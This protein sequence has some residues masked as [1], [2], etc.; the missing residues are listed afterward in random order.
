M[1]KPQILVWPEFRVHKTLALHWASETYSG[2]HNFI[3]KY[4]LYSQNA[5]SMTLLFREDKYLS[6]YQILSW[7]ASYTYCLLGVLFP[8][9]HNDAS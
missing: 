2:G 6:G 3:H 8:D 5:D 1:S 9:T 7:P 4:Y